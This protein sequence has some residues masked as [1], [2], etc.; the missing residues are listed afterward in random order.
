MTT[1]IEWKRRWTPDL[2]V[3]SWRPLHIDGDTFLVKSIFLQG[4]YEVLVTDLTSIWHEDLQ[5]QAITAR[6]KAR[7]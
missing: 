2:S 4:G 6:S 3:S 1:E 7:K 5:E